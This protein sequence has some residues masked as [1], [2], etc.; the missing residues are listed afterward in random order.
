VDLELL[1]GEDLLALARRHVLE[2]TKHR[3]VD[4]RVVDDRRQ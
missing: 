3:P 2:I 1:N 4:D